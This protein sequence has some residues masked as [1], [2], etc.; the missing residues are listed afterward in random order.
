MQRDIDLNSLELVQ[1]L[2]QAGSFTAAA[3]QLGCS[4]TRI[5]LQLK[6]LEQQLGVALFRRTTRQLNLTTAGEQLVTECFPLLNQLQQSL[7]QLQ[8]ADQ[9]LQ[10]KLVISAP[11]DYSAK[12]LVAAVLAFRQQHPALAVELRS[13]DQ[14]KDLIKEGID[15]SVRIGWLKDSSLVARKL[16]QFEQW[17]LASPAYLQQHGTPQTAAELSNHEFIA[18]TQLNAPLHWTLT[19]HGISHS[20]SL[21][22]SLS[23]GSTHTLTALMKAG[24]GIGIL[25][26]YGAIP[27]LENGELVR[28]L[29][30]W[31]LPGG[32]IYAVYPPGSYR[33]A[34]VRAFVSF[35][36]QFI[37]ESA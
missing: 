11:E 22:S 32:G 21:Q 33:P 15:L 19:H 18:F 17:L 30:A 37:A 3:E 26:H 10:G 4:K 34:R 23:T 7:Q 29:P 2:A 27:L 24:A 5:S 12:V 28:L 13:S 9:I 36:Q 25:P 14:V 6:A 16:G 20:V 35:L 31:Q 1:A 8:T